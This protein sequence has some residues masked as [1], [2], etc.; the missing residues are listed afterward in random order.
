MEG[1]QGVIGYVASKWAIRGMT[2]RAPAGRHGIRVNVVCPAASRPMIGADDFDS[3]DQDAV[4][5]S[6]P[7]SRWASRKRS[8]A[9]SSSSRPTRAATR[10]LGFIADGGGLAGNTTRGVDTD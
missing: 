5:S 9:W 7:I 10:R 8:R 3:V 6:Q 4:W 1:V 2:V